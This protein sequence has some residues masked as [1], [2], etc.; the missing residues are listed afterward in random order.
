MSKETLQAYITGRYDSRVHNP[1]HRKY[2]GESDFLNF[3]YWTDQT[4]DQRTACENLMDR[5]LALLPD[6][7]G[8]ILD[9]ACGKGG[10]TAYLLN[11]YPP[12]QVVGINISQHQL[13]FARTKAPGCTF[14]WM[15]ATEL[16]F[17]N[18][19]FD[20]IIC[21]EAA[22]HFWTRAQFFAEAH[23]VLKS[24]GGLALSDILMTEEGERT[25]ASRSAANYLPDLD[26]YRTVW[27]RAGFAQVVVEDVTQAC[28]EGYFW[29]VVR[30]FHRRLLAGEIT[31]EQLHQ[32]LHYTY[33][34]VPHMRYYVLARGIKG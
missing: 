5:L 1:E 8:T 16:G 11:R 25:R 21:V 4:P 23:R 7:R 13:E 30:Y 33:G 19:A 12:S 29:N 14:L 20:N 27:E 28:W 6:H 18:R 3:G 31:I 32:G 9:V 26:A 15:D 17:T 24:G 10:S 2:F 22:F 34:H